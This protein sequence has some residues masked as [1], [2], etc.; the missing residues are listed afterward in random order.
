MFASGRRHGS[1]RFRLGTAEKKGNRERLGFWV[2]PRL[3]RSSDEKETEPARRASSK[4]GRASRWSKGAETRQGAH[5]GR[6]W[7]A[8]PE[9]LSSLLAAVKGDSFLFENHRIDPP[10]S[11]Y[12]LKQSQEQCMATTTISAGS[13]WTIPSRATQPTLKPRARTTNPRAPR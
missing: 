1:S 9:V 4:L 5:A 11:C 12:D 7:G 2:I 3:Y 8:C 6:R 13:R 10:L